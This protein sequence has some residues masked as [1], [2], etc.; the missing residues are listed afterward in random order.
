MGSKPGSHAADS[1]SAW[2]PFRLVLLLVQ[3][4]VYLRSAQQ[5]EAALMQRVLEMPPGESAARVSELSVLQD[6]AYIKNEAV[7]ARIM[8]A[9][10]SMS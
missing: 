7:I 2:S 6:A 4:A 5:G 9:P 8:R 10:V 1:T 3:D